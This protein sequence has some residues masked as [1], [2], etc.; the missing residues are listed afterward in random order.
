MAR[1]ERCR[2]AA[3]TSSASGD[4]DIGDNNDRAAASLSHRARP[5]PDAPP[6]TSA[7]TAFAR[8]SVPSTVNL[9]EWQ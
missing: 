1:P 2:M 3:P 5:I 7:D 8:A 9:Q 6:V 4:I